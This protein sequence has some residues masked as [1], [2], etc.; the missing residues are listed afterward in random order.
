MPTVEERKQRINALESYMDN[1]YNEYKTAGLEQSF[2]NKENHLNLIGN[3][4]SNLLTSSTGSTNQSGGNQ[5]FRKKIFVSAREAKGLPDVISTGT[6]GSIKSESKKGESEKSEKGNKS[7]INELSF[8]NE[9]IE[10]DGNVEEMHY[11]FVSFHQK[12]KKILSQMEI[13]M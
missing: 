7:F 1:N 5:N 4:S 13:K 2:S 12:S 8:L 6:T 10:H 9:D 11:F 3:Q